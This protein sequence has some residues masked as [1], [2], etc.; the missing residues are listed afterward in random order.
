MS[1]NHSTPKRITVWVQHYG[2]R[3]YLLLQW[4]DPDTGKRKSQSAETADE[5]EA[6][7]K[8]VDLEADLNACRYHAASRMTWE[9]FREIF[10][11]EYLPNVRLGT[12]GCYANAMNLL[13]KVCHLT[14]V[15][16]VTE[17]TLSAFVAG[18]RKLEGSGRGKGDRTGMQ[19]SSIAARLRELQVVLNWAAAQ[20][21]IPACPEFPRVRVPKKK[22][23]PV[24]VEAFERIFARAAG[25]AQ[26]QAFVLCGWLAGLR[27]NEAFSL[28]REPTTEAPYLALDRN[29]I[30]LPAEFVKADED[31]WLPL[32]P[33]LKAAL[34]ALPRH[35]R[36]VF[37]FT[38]ARYRDRV[39]PVESSATVARRIIRLAKKAGVKL[40][41]R[42]LRRGFGCRHA[43]KVPAQVLQKLM[44]HSDIKITMDYYANV[45]AAVE[46]AILGPQHNSLHNTPP[47]GGPDD[48]RTS[49]REEDESAASGNT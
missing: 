9:K 47:P 7:A 15:R 4:I 11:E 48:A 49:P 46:E 10:E 19:S 39:V 33:A 37:H 3:P 29:R 14:T 13:E 44:R 1:G 5:K 41:M 34:E 27:L 8:R 20:K 23:Q 32:D 21:I 16:A 30:V 12:R 36:K 2:D 40:T 17:R 38:D 6:E 22:P 18:L 35:G 24:P 31:Q 26:L 25:D 42:T 45:D 43:G 28:Q